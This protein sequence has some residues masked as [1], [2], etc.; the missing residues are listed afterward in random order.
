[1]SHN[2]AMTDHLDDDLNTADFTTDTA[3]AAEFGDPLAG[4]T[5]W[6]PAKPGGTS[7]RTHK[8]V[9]T[10][11][12]RWEFR[13][14]LLG[15]LVPLGAAIGGVAALAVGVAMWETF[16]VFVKIFCLGLGAIGL[17]AGLVMFL[18]FRCPIVF[19]SITGYYWKGTR[20]PETAL[21]A[22]AEGKWVKLDQIHAL[23]IVSE[24]ITRTDQYSRT[25][26]YTS[27]ELNLVLQDATR[28][29]VVDHTNYAGLRPD[30]ETLAE[31][32]KVPLWDAG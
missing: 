14:G 28:L 9:M 5:A 10:R 32:L 8:L 26:T 4:R 19:D 31:F 21:P 22:D 7:F 12:D 23:Q 20:S 13:P 16:D 15:R 18:Q 1:M 24:V 30:A 25:H 11:P 3:R 17:G 6:T 27:Y 29:N 2:A